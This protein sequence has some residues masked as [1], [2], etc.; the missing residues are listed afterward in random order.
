MQF[1][2]WMFQIANQLSYVGV[3]LASF[4]G[5][6]SI[7]FPIPY[8][9][10]IFWLGYY[11]WNP[12]LLALS[13]GLGSAVGEFM[14]YLLGY[15]GRAAVSTERQRKIDFML[16][17]FSRYG[18][19]TIF[20]FALTPLPDDLLFIPLGI[21][22]YKFIKAFI[23]CLL[24][25]VLMCYLLAYFGRMGGQFILVIFGEE[26]TWI[27][28]TITAILLVVILVVIFKV[29]WER[30]LERYLEKAEGGQS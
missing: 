20:L 21:M 18:F 4:V 13:G 8:T 29:D 27:G 10:L 16:K 2:D 17:V 23:P 15:C 12:I 19:I 9:L 30:F 22:R 11:G 5:A 25:K 24:G 7:V 3:A 6:V 28:I 14:G 26:G 1:L